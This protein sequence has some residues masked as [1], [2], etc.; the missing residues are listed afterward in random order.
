M[1]FHFLAHPFAQIIHGRSTQRKLIRYLCLRSPTEPTSPHA[2]KTQTPLALISSRAKQPPLT[3]LYRS[4]FSNYDL[5]VQ[6]KWL[7]IQPSASH[8][9]NSHWIF[10]ID[11]EFWR[12]AVVNVQPKAQFP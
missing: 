6:M 11:D 9:S 10:R 8:P 2:F 3:H 4:H 7:D 5:T 12:G 1:P